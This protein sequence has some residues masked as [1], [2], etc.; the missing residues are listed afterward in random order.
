[1]SMWS[2]FWIVLFVIPVIAL[3]VYGLFDLIRRRDLS[4]GKRV[5]WALLI[6]F[7]PILGVILYFYIAPSSSLPA[8]TPGITSNAVSAASKTNL[9][10][11]DTMYAEGR[12]TDKEYQA[13]KDRL[14][15]KR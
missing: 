9:A 4:T 2:L 14:E 8:E 5:L 12:L 15:G 7:L 3:W 10:D 6:I 1:M 13:A 11:I